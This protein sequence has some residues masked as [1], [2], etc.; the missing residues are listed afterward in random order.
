MLKLD[1]LQLVSPAQLAALTGLSSVTLWRMR[2]RGEFPQ[3]IQLSPGRVAW[4]AVDIN[5]WLASRLAA[6]RGER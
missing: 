4:R 6:A 5:E 2:G 1:E 3:P